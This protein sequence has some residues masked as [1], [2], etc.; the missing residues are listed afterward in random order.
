MRKHFD[1]FWKAVNSGTDH[2]VLKAYVALIPDIDGF[3]LL[4]GVRITASIL[5]TSKIEITPM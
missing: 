5:V 2:D 1:A 4:E 3:D